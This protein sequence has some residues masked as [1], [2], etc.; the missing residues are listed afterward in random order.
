M[1]RGDLFSWQYTGLLN[2]AGPPLFLTRDEASS[3]RAELLSNIASGSIDAFVP[4][5]VAF[6]RAVLRQLDS[7]ELGEVTNRIAFVPDRDLLEF[8]REAQPV[9]PEFRKD[10]RAH[11]LGEKAYDP[12]LDA[13]RDRILR[14]EDPAFRGVLFG[15]APAVLRNAQKIT[16][17]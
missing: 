11:S 5:L 1:E 10:S 7:T 6:N 17:D 14:V 8:V 12:Y 2:L 16:I 4:K 3:L 9:S 13:L 15:N